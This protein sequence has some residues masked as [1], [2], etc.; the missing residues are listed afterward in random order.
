MSVYV[1]DMQMPYR[2]MKMCHMIADSLGELHAMA[3]KIGVSRA[4]Y[5][6]PPKT[7]HEHYDICQ[8]KRRKAVDAGAIEI[9]WRQAAAMKR[10]QKETGVMGD[11][12]DAERWYHEEYSPTIKAKP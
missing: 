3:G 4:H 1:D 6:G 8:T 7:R 11:P 10:R 9:T 5:Q 2:G 12:N